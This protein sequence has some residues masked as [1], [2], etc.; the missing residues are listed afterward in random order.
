MA[1]GFRTILLAGFAIGD[2]ENLVVNL[3]NFSGQPINGTSQRRAAMGY[4]LYVTLSKTREPQRRRRRVETAPAT[5]K[6]P[7]RQFREALGGLPRL[8]RRD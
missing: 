6:A 5:K 3:G 8:R 1:A 7:Q 2:A 4:A